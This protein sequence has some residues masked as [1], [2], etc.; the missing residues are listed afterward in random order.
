M[1][2]R[3][4]EKP[5]FWEVEVLINENNINVDE[6]ISKGVDYL[7]RNQ[8]EDG[9]V[10]LNNDTRWHVWGTAN[11]ILAV[12]TANKNERAS[13]E[14]AINFLLSAQREDGSFCYTISFAEG[15]YCM[16]TTST[17]VMALATA[18]KDVSKG[19]RF[20]L[21][22]QN[23]DGS[24]EIGIPDMLKHRFWPSITGFVIQTLLSLDMSS[25]QISKGIEFLLQKQQEDGSWGSSWIYYDTPYYPLHVILPA[26]KLYGLEKN[27]SYKRSVSFIKKNQNRDGSWC[28]ETTNKPRPSK[29][30]RTALALNSLLV[31]PDDSDSKSIEK[32]V[33]W[34]I[35]NQKCEGYWDGGYFVNWPGKKEDVFATSIAIR[36]LKRYEQYG[37]NDI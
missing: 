11:S 17:S 10:R 14:K 18:K 32:G 4:L 2:L 24:W 12:H 13:L 15:E 36:A 22:K 21:S 20:M 33:K 19:V 6:S 9:S 29:S 35:R 16:E 27:D 1:N 37:D 26:L 34:L 7:I 31:S 25:N 3:I 23:P 8:K 30:L 5:L 28:M